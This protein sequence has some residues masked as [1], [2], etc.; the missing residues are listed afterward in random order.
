M[1]ETVQAV[2]TYTRILNLPPNLSKSRKVFALGMWGGS[3]GRLFGNVLYL[4]T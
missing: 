1:G 2:D 4:K 3:T